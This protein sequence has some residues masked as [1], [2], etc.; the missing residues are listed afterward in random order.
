MVEESNSIDSE[1]SPDNS[2]ELNDKTVEELKKIAKEK[3]IKG[4]STLSKNELIE[5]IRATK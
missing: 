2:L 4:Y 3:N 1:I 5:A